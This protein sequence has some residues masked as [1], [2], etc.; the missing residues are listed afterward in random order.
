MKS[1]VTIVLDRSGSMRSIRKQAVEFF[2]EQAKIIREDLWQEDNEEKKRKRKIK[3]PGGK[4]PTD[5]QCFVNLVTF[6]DVVDEPLL[7]LQPAGE[8]AD[9]SE[10]SYQPDGW[11]ALYDAIG[12]TIE[13]LEAL[14]DADKASF[15]FVV[16]TDGQEN[17]S[18]RFTGQAREEMVDRI[19]ALKKT[20][21]WTFAFLGSGQ[22]L[23]ELNQSLKIGAGNTYG[24][25]GLTGPSGQAEW[26]AAFRASNI[27]TRHYAESLTCGVAAVEDYYAV[28]NSG[29]TPDEENQDDDNQEQEK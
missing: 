7:W 9:L 2:N 11:T 16:V 19:E 24:A 1:Y 8:L 22:N 27:G 28:S 20:G 18:K 15:L 26:S 29:L 25:A 10:S 3:L 5:I 12:T 13:K 21:R 17:N 14:E 4:V 6:S 23:P